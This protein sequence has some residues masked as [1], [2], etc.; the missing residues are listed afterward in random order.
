MGDSEDSRAHAIAIVGMGC[1]FPGGANLPEIFWENLVAGIDAITPVPSDRWDNDAFCDPKTAGPGDMG[2]RW[3]GFVGDAG[4]FDAGFFGISPKEAIRMDPQQRMLLEVAWECLEDAGIP[5]ES[6]KGSKTGVFVGVQ[7]QSIDY[8]FLQ[9]ADIGNVEFQTNTGG[10][11][12]IIANRLSYFL[13]LRGPS[14]TVDTACSSSIV[15]LHLACQSL[16]SG[17]CDLAFAGGTNLIAAP[18]TSIAYTK[19]S[20]MSPEGR[21]KTFDS[22]A[23]G[24]VRGEGCGVVL[25]KRLSDARRDGDP[26]IAI[27]R[28]TAVNQDGT[29]N[30]LTAPNGLSQQMVIRAALES[31]GVESSRIGYV[32]THGTGTM[33]G[34]PI[35]VGA[36]AS[37]LA[38]EPATDGPCY[39]GAVKTNIGHLESAAGIAGVIKAA[40]CL[41]NRFIPPNLHFKKLNPHIQLEG[42]RLRVPVEG[43]EWVVKGGL[44]F[45]GVSSFGFGGT[46]GHVI[47]EEESL[48]QKLHATAGNTSENLPVGLFLSISAHN[49][50]ALGEVA[51]AYDAFLQSEKGMGLSMRDI[52]S[53]ACLR[54]SHL[55]ARA[56]V[57][58]QTRDQWLEGLKSVYEGGAGSLP[59]A[60][61]PGVVIGDATGRPQV[62]FVFSGQGPQWHAMGRELFESEPVYRRTIERCAS[63][64]GPWNLIEELGR[65][66][67][68]S[69]IDSTE[70]AQPAIFSLQM[71]LHEL[72]K[73]WGVYPDLIIGHSLGEVAAACAAGVLT[74]DDAM[75]VVLHR[76]IVMQHAA[77]KGRMAAVGLSAEQAA[78]EIAGFEDRLVIAVYNSP[79]SVVLSGE[80]AALDEVLA[81]LKGKGVFTRMLPGNCAFHSPVMEPCRSELQKALEGIE[82]RRAGVPIISTVT[83]QLAARVDYGPDYWGQNIRRPV[84]FSD[85][86][87]HAVESGGRVFLEIG[88]HPVL[89]S[90]L[91][92]Y[93]NKVKNAIVLPS[94]R[95]G[96]PERAAMLTALAGLYAVGYPVDWKCHFPGI[97]RNVRLPHYPWQHSRFWIAS[98]AMDGKPAR[99]AAVGATESGAG[100]YEIQWIKKARRAPTGPEEHLGQQGRIGWLVL[101]DAG[102]MG[103]AFAEEIGRRGEKCILIGYGED[104]VGFVKSA[105]ES[106][107]VEAWNVV[108]FQALDAT[109]P[110]ETDFDAFDRGRRLACDGALNLAQAIKS[111]DGRK[112]LR[113]WLVTRGAQPVQHI[114]PNYMQA[115]LWGLG[116][117]LAFEMPDIW[118]GLADLDPGVDA[119]YSSEVLLQEIL[120]SDDDDQV[121]FRGQDRFVPRLSVLPGQDNGQ[122]MLPCGHDGAYLVTG[123]PDGLGMRVALWLAQQG[124]RHLVVVGQDNGGPATRSAEQ[125]RAIENHGATID[126]VRGDAADPEILAAVFAGF[127]KTAPAL[128][129][130]IHAAGRLEPGPA[131]SIDESLIERTF[132][133]KAKGALL[134]H[135]LSA[136]KKLDF[137]V[138][139]SSVSAIMGSRDLAHF[140]AASHFLDSLAHFRRAQGLPALS[141][142][143]GW[144]PEG[145]TAE[146][147][148]AYYPRIGLNPMSSE[149]AFNGLSALL[150]AGRTQAVI[151]SIEW[152]VFKPICE[153]KGPFPFLE[154]IYA[155]E[156]IPCGPDES[157][158]TD[159][160]RL[161]A[162]TAAEDHPDVLS[163]HVREHLSH[164]LGFENPD[165]IDSREG[166]FNMGMDSITTLQF[167][168]RLE[169]SIGHAFPATL[170][171][172][173]PN[174]EALCKY[175]IEDVLGDKLPVPFEEAPA[176]ETT[177]R[178]R[179]LT[180]G[181]LVDM[182]EKKLRS[183]DG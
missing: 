106:P 165:D 101:G 27:I 51:R 121:V 49:R 138:L 152:K 148:D 59:E 85:A 34:D 107:E 62:V 42:T 63:L 13:D 5:A 93:L 46:N 88:P 80:G 74:L 28:G 110:E 137:F 127:G 20:F 173:H 91:S 56:V 128:R 23:D 72:L 111:E 70:I 133:E 147:L 146:A 75:R 15:A 3:G 21:C 92:Q 12:S 79:D 33:L 37:V 60:G 43:H 9:L 64:L 154:G 104:P 97:G 169:Q 25:L 159:F 38:T 136:G 108:S 94:L 29:T 55:S 76:G 119:R 117:T 156:Q 7:S 1:R 103:N 130:V 14:F 112:C 178:F 100:L 163:A 24:F 18:E 158:D 78:A 150:R 105:V 126:V 87:Q 4:L 6:L 54:R 140:A 66:E 170:A 167:T 151:T 44:R 181:E 77:G 86:V 41:R 47:L 26:V 135:Q 166:F 113:L 139:F 84:R 143:W 65:D 96:S 48:D 182:L 162:Q 83:G 69:R 124:A 22:R 176:H 115:P 132:R 141:V 50:K 40:L 71:A 17:E 53:T 10:A 30:G 95:R 171:F 161:W 142:N 180:E 183:L 129:G 122:G 2:M 118:G 45:A 61:Q 174:I 114:R 175:L 82:V 11:H 58:G 134:L 39:L 98:R 52:A 16:R 35:E 89:G 144:W 160:K 8:Y 67:R 57:I 19:L 68:A 123:N 149:D 36:L 155:G 31:A 153:A 109:P 168:K 90:P 145:G 81:R 102:G 172:E 177:E 131:A 120:Y 73:S 125:R 32:E 116:R 99:A 164:V 179:G 157:A